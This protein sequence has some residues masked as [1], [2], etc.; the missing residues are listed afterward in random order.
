MFAEKWGFL[1][2][3]SGNVSF[4]LFPFVHL[5]FHWLLNQIEVQIGP[6]FGLLPLL[7]FELQI[8]CLLMPQIPFPFLFWPMQNMTPN[9]LFE[10]IFRGGFQ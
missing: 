1:F 5:L 4:S 7:K 6:N 9:F 10:R 2:M 3:N 8:A